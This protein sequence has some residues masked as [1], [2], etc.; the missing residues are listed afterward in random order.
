MKSTSGKKRNIIKAVI[1]TVLVVGALGSSVFASPTF[2]NGL[3]CKYTQSGLKG[4]GYTAY[5]T[6]RS[7]FHKSTDYLTSASKVYTKTSSEQYSSLRSEAK[8]EKWG[9]YGHT[10]KYTITRWL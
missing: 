3:V 7:C 8:Q 1:C 10:G 2:C 9:L 5:G 4:I 6:T